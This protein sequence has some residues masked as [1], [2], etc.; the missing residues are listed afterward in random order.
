M[1]LVFRGFNEEIEMRWTKLLQL[2]AVTLMIGGGVLCAVLLSLLTSDAGEQIAA[3]AG[4]SVSF[5]GFLLWF[6]TSAVHWWHN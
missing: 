2:I 4:A 1:D 5:C 6:G 3:I